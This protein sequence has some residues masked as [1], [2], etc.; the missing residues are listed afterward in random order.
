MTKEQTSLCERIKRLGYVQGNQ[1][2]LYGEILEVVSDPVALS[3]KIVFLEARERRSGDLRRIRI[4]IN[5]IQ[6][7]GNR[8]IAA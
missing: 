3:E 6:V 8:Y 2:K 5:V 1:V 4:P 7:A